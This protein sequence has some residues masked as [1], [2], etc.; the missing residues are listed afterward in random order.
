M[1]T[2]RRT[3]PARRDS[4]R[5]DRGMATAEFAVALPAVAIVLAV[6]LQAIGAGVDHVRCV[7]A[8]RLGARS[9]AR[10]DTPAQARAWAQGA[11][12]ASAAV[13]VATAGDVVTVSV[14]VARRA[15]VVGSAWVVRAEATAPREGVPP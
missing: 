6:G 5:L 4:R 9:L 3:V 7:D 11:A 2:P 12:P 1:K 10:G 8:A 15:A 14:S 13:T